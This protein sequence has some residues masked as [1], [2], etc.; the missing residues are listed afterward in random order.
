MNLNY[1]CKEEKVEIRIDP[2]IFPKEVVLRSAYKFIDR[3]WMNIEKPSD[4]EKVHLTLLPRDPERRNKE[5]LERMAL[6]FNTYLITS[7][8][9][10]KEAERYAEARNA[11][12]K[13]AMLSQRK[14]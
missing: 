11:M 1:T 6:Q 10:D 3:A 8:V 13:S 5:D 9:E 12:V 2:K 4:K 7:F 14:R